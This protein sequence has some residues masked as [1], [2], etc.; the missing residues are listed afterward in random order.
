MQTNHRIFYSDASRMNGLDNSSIDLVVTSPPYPMIKLWDEMFSRADP[1]I[2]SFLESG[3]SD[4]AWEKMH[5]QLDQIWLELDRVTKN[6]SHLCINIGDAL[7]SVDGNFKLYPNQARITSSLCKLG[8][9]RLP[10]IIWRKS[11]TAPTKFMGSGML[12]AGAYVTLEHEY[13]LIFRKGPKRSFNSKEQILN[14]R[15]SALFW[16]E[17]NSWFSDLWEISGTRQAGDGIKDRA[18]SAAYPLA[19]PFRLINMYSVYGDT[20]LDPFLGT[21]TTILAAAAAARNS[22]GFERDGHFRDLIDTRIRQESTRLGQINRKR[23]SDH[24]EFIDRAVHG[25][26]VFKHINEHYNF[27]VVTAQESQLLLYELEQLTVN[28]G[29]IYTGAY[30]AL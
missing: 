7:R 14:R 5:L 26:K 15:R 16:E 4:A 24:R 20:V 2:R 25:K 29:S 17:R 11:T 6:G 22:V 30:S 1:Q 23:L 13:I 12:P 19:V 10:S 3:E 28:S 27:P 8:F 21:G 18:R 9:N